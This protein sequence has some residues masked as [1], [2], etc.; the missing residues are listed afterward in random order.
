MVRAA[1]FRLGYH[2]HVTEL[3]YIGRVNEHEL[4]HI[5]ELC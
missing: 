3:Q 2:L 5:P 1:I 4:E